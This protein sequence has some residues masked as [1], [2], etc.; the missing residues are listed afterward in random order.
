M[1]SSTQVS[2]FKLFFFF[3][4]FLIANEKSNKKELCGLKKITLNF[5]RMD[6]HL[7]D[8]SLQKAG[9]CV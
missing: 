5:S 2:E 1:I 4:F 3:F 7:S 9:W 6:L 8:V